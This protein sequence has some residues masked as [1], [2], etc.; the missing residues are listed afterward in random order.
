MILKRLDVSV[1]PLESWRS[2]HSNICMATPSKRAFEL[3][4]LPD[5]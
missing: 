2:A 4:N 5:L 1:V 3:P